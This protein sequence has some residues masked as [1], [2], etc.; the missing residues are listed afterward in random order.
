MSIDRTATKILVFHPDPGVREGCVR[1]LRELGE[2]PWELLEAGDLERAR[3]LIAGEAPDCVLIGGAALSAEG[4]ALLEAP[5]A[6]RG[7]SPPALVRL[8]RNGG[9]TETLEALRSGV[10]VSLDLESLTGPM[11]RLAIERAREL[12]ALYEKSA[13]CGLALERSEA[14]LRCARRELV[15]Q[16]EALRRTRAELG[17]ARAREQYLATHDPLTEL[18]NRQLFQELL[19]KSVEYARRHGMALAVLLLDL[20]HFKPVNDSFGHGTGDE[21]LRCVAARLRDA[22]RKSDTVARLE[23]DEFIVLLPSLAHPRDAAVVAREILRCVGLP[24]QVDA[25]E[26]SVTAS[27]GI[28]SFP[29]DGG[30]PEALMSCA[31]IAM[32]NAKR[33]GRNG[34][35]FFSHDRSTV[36][37]EHIELDRELREGLRRDAFLLHYQ[38]KIAC[39][40]ERL[41]GVEALMRWLHPERGLTL[42]GHFIPAAEANGLIVPL[43]ELALLKACS[44]HREWRER[45]LDGFSISVNVSYRQLRRNDLVD[46]VR[47]TLDQTELLPR[48]LELEI[49]ES[50]IMDDVETALAILKELKSL[51]VRISIDDFGTGYSSL[52]V[53][54]RFPIDTLKIDR[55]FVHD[56]ATNQA[57]ASIVAAI[58]QMARGLGLDSVAEGVETEQER[59]VLM[60]LGCEV[61]QGYLFGRPGPPEDLER[62]WLNG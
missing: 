55:S 35:R 6:G 24:Y 44:Q 38:P 41:V 5:R 32:Y 31:D 60:E 9:E 49:T 23:G 15:Q 46:T 25:S 8:G 48:K 62:R 61:M 43:G 30:S 52:A 57:H 58:L 2:P 17:A 10:L 47:R 22:I 4:L 59:E 13:R 16:A 56:I 26:V 11:L 33:E 53:L 51:G 40:E 20:D 27:I 36:R 12:A 42:P 7:G 19:D 3:E 14:L 21:L 50:C 45:G 37:S 54:E 18:P 39:R 34:Y 28:A 1:L 29:E